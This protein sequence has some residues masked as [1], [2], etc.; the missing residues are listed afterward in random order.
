[1]SISTRLGDDG[2]TSLLF[3]RRVSKTHPR[4]E[5]CGSI[6]ELSAALGLARSVSP[7]PEKAAL[8]LSIQKE[9]W[10]L[11]GELATHEEDAEKYARSDFSKLQDA[12]LA[13]LDSEVAAH[14]ARTVRFKGFVQPGESLSS[15]FLHQA[16]TICRRA[17]RAVC[18]ITETASGKDVKVVRPLIVRYLNRLSDLLWLIA[19]EDELHTIT[20][21]ESPEP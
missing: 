8:L 3:N 6:D 13:T 10:M 11:M 21:K 1:M 15:A 5:A 14:E 17:E 18:R 19:R 16:R 4:I 9:L 20:A 12:H 7:F 2:Q